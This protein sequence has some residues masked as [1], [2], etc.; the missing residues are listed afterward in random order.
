VTVLGLPAVLA[1]LNRIAG[2]IVDAE[3]DGLE[4]A[5]ERIRRAWV[6]NIESEGLVLTG[7][8]RDS[9]RVEMD[10]GNAV[11][12]TDL[13][14]PGVLE[15]GDSRIPSH[16]VA[17]RAFDEHGESAIGLVGNAIARVIR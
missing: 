2:Q 15:F 5:G 17:E 12:Y 16:P 4:D 8:Y 10:D 14:Y 3:G 6:D 7:D 11:V 9:I 1:N 13:D